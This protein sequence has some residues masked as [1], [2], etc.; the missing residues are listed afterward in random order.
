MMFS[1]GR[2][3]K[4]RGSRRRAFAAGALTLVA[5]AAGC[6]RSGGGPSAVVPAVT[7]GHPSQQSVVEYLELTG[8]VAASKS[9]NLV[10]RVPGFLESVNFKDG[11]VVQQGQLLFVIEQPPYVEQVKLNEAALVRAQAELDRQEAM[12][13]ENATARTT[14]EN[15]VS[16]RDQ[17]KAQL[18]LAKINL[19]YTKVTAPF[20]GRIGARQVDPGNLVGS[21][22]PT[23]LATLEQLKP[24][25]V[26]FN[27]NEREALRLRDLMRQYNIAVGSRVGKEPVEVALQNETGYPHVGVLDFADNSLSTS[28]GTIALRGV[29]VNGDTALVPG[30]F[31]RVRLPMGGPR[32]MLV[33]PGSAIGSDQQGDFVYV[34]GADDVVERRAIVRGPLTPSGF[35]IS[36]GLTAADRVV[37]NGL[38]NARAGEKVSP[39][40]GPAPT[41][42]PAAAKP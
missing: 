7:V 13:K 36:T 3:A 18:E 27:L 25:Y 32:S 28:T 34:V 4:P 24:I 21:G 39:V 29:F 17:A 23:T 14:V 9:V 12:M 6:H 35:A 15:W 8:T 22:A 41:P 26:T 16:Q 11:D 33:I 2:E 37:V 30:L 42:A 10:A 40:E 1:R 19:A 38:L 5:A 20:T 31:A